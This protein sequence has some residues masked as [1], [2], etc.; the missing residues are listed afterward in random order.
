MKEFISGYDF[1]DSRNKR[2]IKPKFDKSTVKP[3]GEI[4]CHNCI[5]AKLSEITKKQ[6]TVYHCELKKYLFFGYW[7]ET[8]AKDCD[9]FKNKN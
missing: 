9:S 1:S 6:G 2:R 7:R 4:S 5:N 8:Q 3:D